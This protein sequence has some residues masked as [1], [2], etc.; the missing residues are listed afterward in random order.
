MDPIFLN[1]FPITTGTGPIAPIPKPEQ[2]QQETGVSFEEVFRRQLEGQ[3]ELRFSKHA[4]QRVAQRG[5]GLS[6]DSLARLQE[7]ARLAQEK[8]LDDT[9]ILVDNTAYLVSVKNS[10][11]ITTVNH[12]DLKGSVFTNIDGAVII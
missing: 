5:I 8:G 7:G 2:K 10:T 12:E 1:R 3:E 6:L 9:L 11:V 4:A